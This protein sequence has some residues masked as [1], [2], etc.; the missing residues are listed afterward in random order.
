LVQEAI[1]NGPVPTGRW[2]NC[3]LVVPPK[4]SGTIALANRARSASSGAHGLLVVTTTVYAPSAATLLIGASMKFQMLFGL[5]ACS[6]EKTTSLEVM[7]APVE[8]R[9]PR[10][11][12]KVHRSLSG[13]SV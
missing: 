6:M 7:A 13:D 5:S 8:N 11:R 12:R 3:V 2:K 4:L 1:S 10:R 9:T